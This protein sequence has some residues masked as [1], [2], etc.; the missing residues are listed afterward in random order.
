MSR[1]AAS[2]GRTDTHEYLRTLGAS[3]TVGRDEL[4]VPSGRPIDKERWAA[5]IDTVGSET[6][7]TVLRQTRYRG[8]VA[9]CGLAGGTDLPTTVLPFILRN[10]GLLGIDSVQCLNL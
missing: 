1:V 8:A 2:T 9:A 5:A 10:V 7:A 6:L 4:A 3:T